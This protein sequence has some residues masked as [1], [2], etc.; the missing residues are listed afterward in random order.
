MP[1]S[2]SRRFL[3]F[4]S[5]GCRLALAFLLGVGALL[6]GWA[7]GTHVPPAHAV[8]PPG[9][10]PPLPLPDCRASGLLPDA[11]SDCEGTIAPY[12]GVPEEIPRPDPDAIVLGISTREVDFRLD[13]DRPGNGQFVTFDFAFPGPTQATDPGGNT[14]RSQMGRVTWRETIEAFTGGFFSCRQ[15]DEFWST[16]CDGEPMGTAPNPARVVF[17]RQGTCDFPAT[18]CTYRVTW[19]PYDRRVRKPMLFRVAFEFSGGYTVETPTGDLPCGSNPLNGCAMNGGVSHVT[20]ATTP[21]PALDAIGAVRRRG[22]KVIE[23]DGSASNPDVRS[24]EWGVQVPDVTTSMNRF[25]TSGDPVF[26]L[27]FEAEPGIPASFF[28]GTHTASLEVTDR[29]NRTQFDFVQYS[30]LEPAG[31][32]GPLEITSFVLV[33]VDEDGLATL[34]ATV[35][36]KS[37]AAITDVYVIGTEGAGLISPDSTPQLVTL[38][39]DESVEF[40]ITV[41]FDARDVLTIGAKAFG[42]SD[43]GPVKSAPAS[44]Q[45]NRDGS[46]TASTTVSQASQPGDRTLQVA[47]N[48]GFQPGDYVVIN[49][50]GANVEARRV[51]A[52]GSLIFD[53]PLAEP[54]AVGEP[55]TVFEN[56]GD[57]TGPTIDVTSPAAGA[58]VCQGAP[59]VATFTCTD[60]APAAGVESC[61][62][63][64]TSGQALDTATPG[65]KQAALRAWDIVGNVTEKTITWT[66][67]ACDSAID[68]FRC[69]QAKP[70]AG[71]PK[72]APILGVRVNGSFDDVL[73][74]VKKPLQLCAPADTLADGLLD[75][76]THLEAYAIK[77]AKG[78]PKPLPQKGRTVSSQLGA[79]VIDS[80]KPAQLLLPTAED[81]ATSPNLTVNEVD[82][83]TCYQAKLAKGQPKLAKDLQLTVGDQ[84]TDPPKRVNLKK[85]VRLC[86]PVGVNGGPTKHAAHLLC[87]QV[88]ATKGRCADAAP[89]NAGGGCKKEEDCG[90]VKGQTTFC[91][92]QAKFAV[93]TGR[94]VANDLDAG[95]LDAKKEDVL[96]LPAFLAP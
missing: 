32:E 91:A 4:G 46:T 80:G 38:D 54:H 53:A 33:D 20:F 66:V 70:A 63:D 64:I 48:D 73:V 44:K 7:V 16:G 50:A 71:S 14:Y 12:L 65:S 61:G 13:A 19:G 82:R 1:R 40:T 94:K 88:A 83:F 8:D 15:E 85:V 29:W 84:F 18:A 21:P 11:S 25:I 90:G 37:D 30:F 95:T 87:F 76:E 24:T 2:T 31:T 39:A 51:G 35:K 69:Y 36:N 55:V 86:T 47:S 17:V 41:L 42:T 22:A 89:S 23:F 92:A 60:P 96:C 3:G 74:D 9:A 49:V 59:L 77:V 34:K 93:R 58:F 43:A 68:A 62:E 78:Q 6:S 75:A 56:T 79:L 5:T 67:G 57:T 28:Q 52:L 45:V 26:T 72:F 27:D 10:L 81:P